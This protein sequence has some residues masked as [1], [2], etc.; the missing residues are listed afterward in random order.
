MWERNFGSYYSCH[1]ISVTFDPS[2]NNIAIV[3]RA[4]AY[5]AN[6]NGFFESIVL[7]YD[8]NGN[9]LFSYAINSS[10]S[11]SIINPFIASDPA[12]NS[13]IA[14]HYSNGRAHVIRIENNGIFTYN[15]E[16]YTPID[17]SNYLITHFEYNYVNN[18]L[19]I[20]GMKILNGVYNAFLA[21]VSLGSGMPL[22]DHWFT[23]N[24]I[25]NPK[26]QTDANGNSYI[27]GF[28]GINSFFKYDGAGNQIWAG[29]IGANSLFRVD[30]N[31]NLYSFSG[32]SITKTNSGNVN[33][34]LN[35]YPFFDMSDSWIA[36]NNY[37][38]IFVTAFNSITNTWQP[39]LIK[40]N[41]NHLSIF[42]QSG[43]AGTTVAISGT[44]FSSINS[45]TFNGI[46]STFTVVDSNHI[47]AIVPSGLAS[48]DVK[49][50]SS[51]GY[52]IAG[53]ISLNSNYTLNLKAFIE[54]FYLGNNI[55]TSVSASSEN[56]AL[57]DTVTIELHLANSPYSLV[58]STS[59][60]I[61]VSGNGSFEFPNSVQG[62]SYY[63]VVR[64]RNALE[65][66]SA[67]PVFF[68]GTSVSYD[69]TNAISKAYGNNLKNLGNGNFALFSGNLSQDAQ[70]NTT[71]IDLFENA[72]E[73]F[74]TGYS[75][76]DL[77]GDGI[78]ESVD[79]C[80]L[81]NNLGKFSVHP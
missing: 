78:V 35:T 52:I 15:T 79:Y 51:N 50:S 55:M 64:H 42:P 74:T 68:N 5:D 3:F 58:Y 73:T 67:T 45:V 7:K 71:D 75:I 77:N 59:A 65:T 29:N 38:I 32:S 24:Q 54:G 12:G 10:N 44:A 49:I 66:W 16:L 14:G 2:G 76:Y 13:Y 56:S 62:N 46:S 18:E 23:A 69:F 8:N 20:S 27:D 81:E 21:K 37:M 6:A 41:Q 60:G 19:M 17:A 40:F 39:G 72:T 47:T 48:G 25:S 4:Y 33:W 31:G 43:S 28:D 61:N 80:M 57:C 36:S 30:N 53:T 11:N 26:M 9:L 22:W 34:V 70:I 1:S 63:I